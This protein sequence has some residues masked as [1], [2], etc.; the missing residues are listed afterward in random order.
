[1]TPR[2][3][4][5]KIVVRCSFRHGPCSFRH[6]MGSFRHDMGSLRHVPDR[7]LYATPS[8]PQ[9]HRVKNQ[10]V[11][12]RI[13]ATFLIAIIPLC[14]SASSCGRGPSSISTPKNLLLITVDTLRADRLGCTG[15]D[16]ACT[17][18]LDRLAREGVLFDTVVVPVPITLPSHASLMT[19]FL[20]Y[21]MNLRDNQPF[22]LSEE[23]HTL[24]E[25]LRE[26]GYST[27][28][29]VSGATLAPGCGL[30]QGF[31]SYRFRPRPRSSRVLLH[32]APADETTAQAL[33]LMSRA[34]TER[35]FFLWVHYFDPHHPYEPPQAWRGRTNH[36]YDDEIA[37]TDH[38][39]GILLDRLK[40]MG[41]IENTLV[42]VTSDH[43]EGLG[44]HGEPTHAFFLFDSTVRVPLIVTGPGVV[45][46]RR[47]TTQVRLRDLEAALRRL[48]GTRTSSDLSDSGNDGRPSVV[49]GRSN[50]INEKRASND[51]VDLWESN[52]RNPGVELAAFIRG[53]K[54]NIT[55]YPAFIESLYCHRGFRWS[56]LTAIR[57]GQGKLIRGARDE[58]F[59]LTEDPDETESAGIDGSFAI[60]SPNGDVAALATAMDRIKRNAQVRF[61]PGGLI[62]GSLPGYFGRTGAKGSSFLPEKENRTLPH[63]M[64]MTRSIADLLRAVD[65][66][67]GRGC[68][69][70][71]ARL[72]LERLVSSDP[73]NPTA[74][75]WLGRVLREL[76]VKEGNVLLIEKAHDVF[77]KALSLDPENRDCRKMQTWCLIQLGEFKRAEKAVNALKASDDRDAGAYELEGFLYS[78]RS[79]GRRINPL[80]DPV[81]GFAAFDRSLEL[82]GDNPR[83]LGWLITFC[84]KEGERQREARYRKRFQTME[85]EGWGRGG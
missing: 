75:F 18:V 69:T 11:A 73:Q 58:Y 79:S 61:A 56:Q 27:M 35:P 64:D 21:E 45:G 65:H 31:D 53:E 57:T 42:A 4:G 33:D 20:P 5:L 77:G 12:Q 41:R 81:R 62:Q 84:G 8:M 76:G 49:D 70:S 82:N 2:K 36:P 38:Q 78:S 22:R 1:M 51:H 30:E 47:C 32:E 71:Q 29:V 54:S 59:D 50:P 48:V 68:T 66:G 67:E 13:L 34:E 28:A 15:H 40:S 9:S 43:G 46:G 25:R 17:P 26:K 14:I 16:E 23:A 60:E 24:A 44:D 7:R 37:F 39:I 74:W 85:R 55:A 80:Y 10:S 83:L 63:P 72:I 19:G 52:S 6:D 3:V